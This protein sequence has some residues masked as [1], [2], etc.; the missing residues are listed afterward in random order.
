VALLPPG[1]A[2]TENTRVALARVE[3][4]EQVASK[5]RPEVSALLR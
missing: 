3:H 4:A 1:H 5:T 2:Y